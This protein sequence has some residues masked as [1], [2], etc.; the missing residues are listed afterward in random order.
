MCTQTTLSIIMDKVVQTVRDVLGDRLDKVI[1]Y[2]SYARGDHDDDSDVDIMV[3]ADISVEDANRLDMDMTRFTSRLGLENDI[4]ISLFVKDCGTFNK[5][6]H[7]EP[8]Y[9]NVLN[10]GV[11]LSA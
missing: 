10:E 6:L 9:Q 11:I 1:L 5:Y 8:F 3:L 7:I 4:V 2:G